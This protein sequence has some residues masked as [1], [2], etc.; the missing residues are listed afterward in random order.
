MKPGETVSPEPS[1]IF[2]SSSP[3]RM[4]PNLLMTPSLTIKSDRVGLDP[5]PSIATAPRIVK[6]VSF[7]FLLRSFDYF[8]H[9]GKSSSKS[10]IDNHFGSGHPF[11]T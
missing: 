10:T 6:V 2:P 4:E 1:T 9:W 3:F 5:V 7:I 11:G 8:E